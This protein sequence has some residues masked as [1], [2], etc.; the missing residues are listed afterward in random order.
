M[1]AFVLAFTLLISLVNPAY[2]QS[3]SIKYLPRNEDMDT[4]IKSYGS[5]PRTLR[6]ITCGDAMQAYFNRASECSYCVQDL[7]PACPDC[8]LVLTPS[9]RA[10]RC[11]TGEDTRY[12]AYDSANVAFESTNCP[13]LNYPVYTPNWDNIC[14]DWNKFTDHWDT[15]A[16]MSRQNLVQQRGCPGYLDTYPRASFNTGDCRGD[17][18]ERD[19]RDALPSNAGCASR[20]PAQVT[21]PYQSLPCFNISP[22]TDPDYPWEYEPTSGF[23]GAK[24]KCLNY[25]N[26]WNAYTNIRECCRRVVCSSKNPQ[27]PGYD[28]NCDNTSCL[29]RINSFPA[30]DAYTAQTCIELY[31]SAIDTLLQ[32]EK[33]AQVCFKEIDPSFVYSFVAKSR[34]SVTVIWQLSTKPAFIPDAPTYF[35]SKIKVFERDSGALVHDSIIHQ[36]SLDAVYSVFCAT[37]I[38]GDVLE[39]GKAYLV[40]PYYFLPKITGKDLSIDVNS[41]T[42]IWIRIR[43]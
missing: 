1:V 19:D 15:G 34:E 30:C 29:V 11:T 16:S 21:S 24:N 33:S 2:A 3:G 26:T 20:V 17:S 32:S 37:H 10:I 40:K 41:I 9:K 36:K 27:Q 42:L 12:E 25:T 39:P 13:A 35:F 5:S 38:S 31:D 43:E 14:S 4:K 22:N 23:I 18:C 28:Q 6:E 8:C 7:K